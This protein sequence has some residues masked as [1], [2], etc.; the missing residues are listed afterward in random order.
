VDDSERVVCT[1]REH[2][3]VVIL[4][5]AVMDPGDIADLLS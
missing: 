5:E 3:G 2:S 1:H 4:R